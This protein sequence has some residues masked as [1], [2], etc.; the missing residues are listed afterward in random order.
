MKVRF[1][2]YVFGERS[3]YYPHYEKYWGQV[4]ESTN[5]PFKGHVYLICSSDSNI[6]VDGAV[7]WE[8]LEQC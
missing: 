7:H 8:D 2:N 3:P 5:T 4:F 1:K 6:V